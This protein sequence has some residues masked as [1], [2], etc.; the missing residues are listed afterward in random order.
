MGV[1]EDNAGGASK[2]ELTFREAAAGYRPDH[3][4]IRALDNMNRK[5]IC[6]I[7]L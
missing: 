6:M 5:T 4:F 3:C 7:T 2:N 1:T